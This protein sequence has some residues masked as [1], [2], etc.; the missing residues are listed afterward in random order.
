M[1]F[2]CPRSSESWSLHGYQILLVLFLVFVCV[3]C[4]CMG[5]YVWKPG[6]IFSRNLPYAFS[7]LVRRQKL[8]LELAKQQILLEWQTSKP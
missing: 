2:M 5:T 4:T 1:Y 6:Y 7:T 3:L 8:E